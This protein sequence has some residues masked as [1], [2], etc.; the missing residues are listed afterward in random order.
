LWVSWAVSFKSH[1]AL[2]ATRTFQAGPRAIT[3]AEQPPFAVDAHHRRYC[4]PNLDANSPN[5]LSLARSLV[6][7]SS[8]YHP[9]TFPYL[10][11]NRGTDLP[12]SPGPFLLFRSGHGRN[13]QTRRSS[14]HIFYISLTLTYLNLAEFTRDIGAKGENAMRARLLS[15][16][17]IDTDLLLWVCSACSHTRKEYISY[18]KLFFDDRT[19]VQYM[20]E[21][22]GRG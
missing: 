9:P 8:M 14:H 16:F 6:I 11:I 13:R 12:E 10:T 20:A 18:R 5:A 19:R 7:T 2:T 4:K 15:E 17:P 3:D 21:N 22:G 1:L